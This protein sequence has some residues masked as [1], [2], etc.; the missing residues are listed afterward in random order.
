MIKINEIK[1]DVQSRYPNIVFP[2][3]VMEPI[4]WGRRPNNRVNGKFAIVDQNNGNVF[5]IATDAYKPIYHEEVIHLVEE[6]A[7]S[8]PEFGT[9]QF[10]VNMLAN[11]GKLQVHVS[12]PDVQFDINPKVGDLVR[13]S[14]DIFSSYDLG[15]KYG[16]RLSGERLVCTNGMTTG[17]LFDS[18]KKR[19]LTSLDPQE[20]AATLN[21]G[22]LKFSDQTDLWRRWANEKMIA[23]EYE[24]MWTEELPFSAP[25]REKIEALPETATKLLLPVALKSGELTRWDFYNVIQQYV[26]HEIRSEL[27][28]IEISPTVTKAFEKYSK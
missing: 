2:S 12:F 1:K 25:E 11:G 3:V 20:L 5:N 9:P 28:Q 19:H 23:S 17:Q 14:A 24:T 18:F 4:W 10:K 22:L 8:L 15:W 26:T 13:P 7:K 27:R 21:N 16:G 6:A